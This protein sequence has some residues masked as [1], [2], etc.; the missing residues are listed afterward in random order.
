[1][2]LISYLRYGVDVDNSRYN[3]FN[4][5]YAQDK[6][7][8]IMPTNCYKGTVSLQSHNA[9]QAK[10]LL[11]QAVMI[12]TVSDNIRGPVLHF[13]QKRSVQ[14]LK[15]GIAGIALMIGS[16]VAAAA[17]CVTTLPIN[18]E[19]LPNDAEALS[20]DVEALPIDE[21]TLHLAAIGIVAVII[22]S[23]CV[24]ILSFYRKKQADNQ[25]NAWQNPL[26]TYQNQRRQVGNE[27]FVYAYSNNLNG[28]IVHPKECNKLWM[29]WSNT[30]MKFYQDIQSQSVQRIK[31]FFKMNPL[32]NKVMNY[33]HTNSMI[34]SYVTTLNRLYLQLEQSF[35][36]LLTNTA[37]A[38][39]KINEKK[40]Q[41]IQNNENQRNIWLAPA[42]AVRNY[43]IKKANE[44]LENS[45]Q[46]LKSR[47][48]SQLE[49]IKEN[50]ELTKE[51]KAQAV[52]RVSK[53]YEDDPIVKEASR[54]CESTIND[55]N[56]L[57]TLATLPIELKF[58]N[59]KQKFVDD[60]SR[61]IKRQQE[62]GNQ[63]IGGY[64][65][66]IRNIAQAF[67]KRR[68]YDGIQ[69]QQ[70]PVEYFNE[71]QPPSYSSL[72]EAYGE[73]PSYNEA[74]GMGIDQAA[75]NNFYRAIH[76]Q[77]LPSA[78]AYEELHDYE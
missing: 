63:Q 46:S 1:M 58:D 33:A 59:N 35:N 66:N 5:D 27:G 48:D 77:P 73:P 29:D 57:Y 20:I 19:T 72:Q 30:F 43:K 62:I 7:E 18:A 8:A 15:L 24:T 53:G 2:S 28:K 9:N 12:T 21:G 32:Q 4:I 52:I 22:T 47:R 76:E 38:I 50:R 45:I 34:P 69:E 60:A 37:E 54:K 31:D 42:K 3:R 78:P 36:N 6:A 40:S 65:I 13:W 75:L 55:Y 39:N 16:G 23:L 56:S 68:D 41:L 61:L 26:N 25:Y 64:A 10:Q 74:M 14:S 44:E 51:Q 11:D 71:E 70:S 17:H 49:S 67:I